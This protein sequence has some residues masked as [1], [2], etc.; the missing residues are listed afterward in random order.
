[1]RNVEK[2]RKKGENEQRGEREREREKER[3]RGRERTRFS[4]VESGQIKQRVTLF[5][6]LD[7]ILEN[8]SLR[9][10]RLSIMRGA[11]GS[12]FI[13]RRDSFDKVLS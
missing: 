5:W 3:R 6:E 7:E 9:G 4:L 12:S 13:V 2:E 11:D 1:M 10:F 8:S